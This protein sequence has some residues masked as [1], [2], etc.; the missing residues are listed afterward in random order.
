MLM[1]AM[2]SSG[3]DAQREVKEDVVDLSAFEVMQKAINLCSDDIA[4]IGDMLHN[5]TRIQGDEEI[6]EALENIKEVALPYADVALKNSGLTESDVLEILEE[7]EISVEYFDANLVGMSMLLG[8]LQTPS[9]RSITWD[10]Y[11][12]CFLDA[13]GLV[14]GAEVVGA[15]AL[16]TLSKSAVKSLLKTVAKESSKKAVP[17]V[18]LLVIGAEMGYCLYV[19]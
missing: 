19:S 4:S 10:T 16:K 11:K 12:N 2:V 15:L 9:T 3:C 7:C 14:V 5:T 1:F 6:L 18:G 8:M 13:T 17:W